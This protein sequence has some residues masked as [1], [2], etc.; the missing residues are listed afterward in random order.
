MNKYICLLV[1][2]IAGGIAGFLFWQLTDYQKPIAEIVYSWQN[3]V[4]YG[5]SLGGLVANLVREGF[6]LEES[7]P[8]VG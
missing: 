5:S 6:F 8:L 3:N 2:I 7:E 4:M 1:G